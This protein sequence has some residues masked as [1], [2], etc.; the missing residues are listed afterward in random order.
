MAQQIKKCTIV[1]GAPICNI[2]FLKANIDRDSFIIAADSGYLKLQK[3]GIM[4][5]VIVADFDSSDKPEMPCEIITFP[6]EKSYTDTFNSVILAKERGYSDITIFFA[7]GGRFDHSYS[8]VLCLDY[9]RKNN[10]NCR[11]VDDKN[12]IS[13]IT[14]KTVI[15]KEY[16]YFSLFAFLEPCKGLKIEGA[17]YNESFFNLDKMD[18]N[19][20]DQ[21]AQ[22][23]H[24]EGDEC[25][26]TLESGTLLLIESND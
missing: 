21:Y 13:L 2:E 6:V 15:K 26:I 24:I 25:T 11:I 8:N 9:C 17:H 16:D 3:A 20:S 14:D 1:S 23:N 5:D 7:I 10:I 19:L 22:S 18:L 12:R 4:P